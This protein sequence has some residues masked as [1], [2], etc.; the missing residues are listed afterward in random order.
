MDAYTKLNEAIRNN[1]SMLCI[2]LDSEIN[3]LPNFLRDDFDGLLNFNCSIIEATQD[4]VSSYKINFAFYEQ[5]G[6]TGIEVMKKTFDYIPIDIMKIADCKRGDIGNTSL[7]YAMACYEHFGADAV[8]LHPYMGLDSVKPFLDFPDK[9]VFML[10]R[11]SNKSGDDFQSLIC[12]GEPLYK[13]VVRKSLEWGG[14]DKIGFVVGATRP[15]ELA[16]IRQIAPESVFLVPGIGTQGGDLK[17]SIKAN[18]FGTAIFNV[19]RGII[20]A[21]DAD[22]FAIKVRDV[23]QNYRDDINNAL[24]GL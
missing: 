15:E 3:R 9:F 6:A 13:H 21:S 17:A 4:I 11:T 1:G 8:T 23:A 7:A 19:S 18:N 22:D 2:G 24:Y 16:E 10:A 14:A 20:Y 5:Y 12:D